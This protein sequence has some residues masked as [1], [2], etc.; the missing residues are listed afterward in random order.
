MN[1][2]A[3]EE[4]R[5]RNIMFLNGAKKLL[6]RWYGWYWKDRGQDINKLSSD[7]E[8]FLLSADNPTTEPNVV[9]LEKALE[10]VREA[11]YVVIPEEKL[12]LLLREWKMFLVWGTNIKKMPEYNL[13]VNTFEFLSNPKIFDFRLYKHEGGIFETRINES[14]ITPEQTKEAYGKE[15]LVT[16]LVIKHILSLVKTLNVDGRAKVYDE[17]LK[18]E[19][20]NPTPTFSTNDVVEF[21][22]YLKSLTPKDMVVVNSEYPQGPSFLKKNLTIEQILDSWIQSKK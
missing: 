4:E 14:P 2:K 1:E 13:F 19:D 6:H 15:G 9:S 5:E 10:V 7:T 20:I 18:L 3:N 22:E 17:L 11:G 16:D 12:A 21:V 8:A